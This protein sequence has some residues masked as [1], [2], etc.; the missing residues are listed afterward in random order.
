MDQERAPSELPQICA[1]ALR[2][3]DAGLAVI[4]AIIVA[5]VIELA[6]GYSGAPCVWLGAIASHLPGGDRVFRIRG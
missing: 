3:H 4:T 5:F 2:L 1:A 6:P